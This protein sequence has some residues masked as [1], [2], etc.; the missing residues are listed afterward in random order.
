MPPTAPYFVNPITE[1]GDLIWAW[2][3][4]NTICIMERSGLDGAHKWT[5][6][7]NVLGAP[8]NPPPFPQIGVAPAAYA[9][10]SPQGFTSSGCVVGMGD[11][12]A[13]VITNMQQNAWK[14]ACDPANKSQVPADW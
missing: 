12:S 13:R 8:G 9:D 3:A 7:N 5:N 6:A 4:V 14:W 1:H 11:G 10:T 2:H